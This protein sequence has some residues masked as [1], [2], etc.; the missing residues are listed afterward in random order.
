MISKYLLYYDGAMLVNPREHRETIRMPDTLDW[1]FERDARLREFFGLS[2]VGN[3]SG[4]TPVPMTDRDRSALEHYGFEWYRLPSIEEV[5]FD[6]KYL[7]RLYPTAGPAFT[8]P[9]HHGDSLFELLRS[10]HR[11]HAGQLIAVER[12]QK[13]GYLP[14]NQ[15]FYGT[16]YG[17]AAHADPI[18]GYMGRAG[19]TTR[20]RYDHNF[21]TLT[22][23]IRLIQQDWADAGWLPAGYRLSLCPPAVFNL[24]GTIFHPEW[25]HTASL[26][27]GFYPD[28]HG[29]AV[30][31]GVGPNGPGDFSFVRQVE[32]ES[33][34]P[35]LGFRLALMPESPV[36]GTQ[37]LKQFGDTDRAAMTEGA[38]AL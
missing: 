15:Q 27:L 32:T 29:N 10:G 8:A 12:T 19:F 26:E 7:H 30:C 34:W 11:K 20:T 2:G 23:L 33:E 22:A 14:D 24:V 35:L 36:V 37:T 4:P 3:G 21:G 13:P 25:S 38:H 18:V 31:F 6:D 17:F 9:I 5:P 28:E 16:A 1:T